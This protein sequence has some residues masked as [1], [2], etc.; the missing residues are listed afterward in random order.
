MTV[1]IAITTTTAVATT[2]AITNTKTVRTTAGVYALELV[3]GSQYVGQSS[4]VNARVQVQMH[5]GEHCAAAVRRGGGVK[6]RL[7]LLTPAQS[8]L[9]AWEQ[10]ETVARMMADEKGPDN[11][12]GWEFSGTD[13]GHRLSL[14]ELDTFRLLAMGSANLCRRCGR[15]GHMAGQCTQ[16]FASGNDAFA[17][18]WLR[19]TDS[20]RRERI[21]LAEKN[22][23]E[24]DARLAKAAAMKS[25]FEEKKKRKA[26]E[27]QE[28]QQRKQA[29]EQVITSA[30]VLRSIAAGG[31]HL[32]ARTCSSH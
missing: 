19:R 18:A 29:Q 26:E 1:Y 13:K 14:T 11:V 6:R 9:N 24:R 5:L 17:A 32:Q 30:D 4:D 20:C 22:A 8:D 12:R 15:P 27:E 16:G 23:R 31:R 7:E 2:T 25:A 10:A 3:D 21:L 28:E